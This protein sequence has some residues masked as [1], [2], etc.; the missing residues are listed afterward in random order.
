MEESNLNLTNYASCEENSACQ[1]TCKCFTGTASQVEKQFNDFLHVEP[2]YIQ[3]ILQSESY[4]R[5]ITITIFY[6]K[7]GKPHFLGE[8]LT[9]R[10]LAEKIG[11]YMEKFWG[12]KISDIQEEIFSKKWE[13]DYKKEVKK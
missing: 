4:G 11:D 8:H 6:Y 12:I 9:A 1:L 7:E 2:V 3:R 5:T 13:S 10:I